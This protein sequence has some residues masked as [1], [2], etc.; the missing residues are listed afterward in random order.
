MDPY[1]GN[2]PRL[3]SLTE[4][5]PPSEGIIKEQ[6]RRNAGKGARVKGKGL[7]AV[8]YKNVRYEDGLR[9]WQPTPSSVLDGIHPSV[10]GDYQRAGVK[11]CRKRGMYKRKRAFVGVVLSC[12]Q[13]IKIHDTPTGCCTFVRTKVPL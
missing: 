10:G 9:L 3:P 7:S 8:V 2:P 13:S 11:K 6:G 1:C 12:A 4:S 5:T